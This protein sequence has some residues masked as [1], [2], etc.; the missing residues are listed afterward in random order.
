MLKYLSLKREFLSNH[1]S[2]LEISKAIGDKTK[3]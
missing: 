1:Y 3:P 2:A